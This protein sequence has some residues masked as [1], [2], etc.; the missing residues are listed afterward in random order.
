MYVWLRTARNCEDKVEV[1]KSEN[2]QETEEIIRRKAYFT[3]EDHRVV[4]RL[5]EEPPLLGS[6]TLVHILHQ[7]ADVVGEVIEGFLDVD[8]PPPGIAH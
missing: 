8:H 3:C 7:E 5:N 6:D 2:K 4:V 1:S